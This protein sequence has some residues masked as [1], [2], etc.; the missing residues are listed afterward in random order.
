MGSAAAASAELGRARYIIGIDLG[1]TNTVVASVDARDARAGEAGVAPFRIPQLIAAGTMDERPQLPSFVYLDE[2]ARVVGELARSEGARQPGRTIASAKSWLCHGGV[3][4][5]AAILPWGVESARKLSPVEASALVLEHLRAAWDQAHA[6]EEGARFSEQE[7]VVTVPAS[8]DEAARELAL[9]AA[10]KAGLPAVVLLEEPQAAFYAWMN[11]QPAARLLRPGERVLVFDV[12]GGT[13]DFTL[14]SVKEG[15]GFERTAVGDHLLLG[16]DNVDL[17]LAKAVE[18]RLAARP[19]GRKLE[20]LEWHELVHA[21]RLA[22]ESLLSEEGLERVPVTVSGRGSR[23]IGGTLREELTRAELEQ[24][25]YEGFFPLVGPRDFARRSRSGLHEFGLPYAADAAITRH[26][27]VF[28]ARHGSP[29]IDAV[30]FNGGFMTPPALRRRVLA[31]LEHWQPE[32]GAPRELV[33]RAPERAVAEGAAYYGLV[34][35]GL[36]TR[37][38]GGT[39]RSFYAG[40]GQVEERETAVCVAPMGLHEGQTVEL[41][42]DFRLVTNRPVSFKLY[43]STTREDAAGA[44]VALG[45]DTAEELLE[46]PP[47]VTALRAPG[48]GE[49]TVRLQIRLTELGALEIWCAEPAGEGRWRLSFDMRAGG[50]RLVGEAGEAAG[51]GSEAAEPAAAPPHPALGEA[52]ALLAALFDGPPD[53]VAR[54]MKQLEERLGPRDEWSTATARGLFDA[55]LELEPRR[56]R[57]AEHEARWLHL[58]GFCLRPG[59]GAPL[60]DWRAKSLWLIYQA[61]LAHE[62]TEQ[63]RLAWW[64]TW[65]RIAGG[66]SKG[67]QDQIWL[68]LSPIFVPGPQSKRKWYQMKPSREEL[69]EMLRCLANL[70]RLSPSSKAALGDQLVVRLESKKE[71]ADAINLWALARLGSR[72]PLYGPLDA[73]VPADTAAAWTR[74]ILK[75]AWPEP[76][77]VA[78]S[79]AQLARRTGDRSRDV[80]EATRALVIDWLKAG[81]AERAATLVAEVV[82]LEAREQQVAFG[83]SLP[84]GL[85]LVSR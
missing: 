28:L 65:R 51:E 66:L 53:G 61:G 42:H 73:G 30:L 1:T 12:G 36:G 15:G 8:F 46:L 17:A 60:D 3:D 41:E 16:G 20:T 26:L 21:C 40:V 59:T 50:A 31:Q 76:R 85:R 24:I 34:R 83:D 48:R 18:A 58:A 78:F 57:S 25:L 72:T 64:I 19:D 38:G 55:A 11:A 7:L 84:P 75:Y 82:A 10:R 29:R 79:L 43:S 45:E 35:R 69:G 54:T 39:P 2:E 32:A 62:N 33:A 56:K 80:D 5:R 81:G 37:I 27:A 22:K 70:E 13:T 23:L 68:P 63:C 71:R 14:I 67:Q 44:V 4:R 6:G 47:I 49:V 52:R 9:E 77:K 74:A